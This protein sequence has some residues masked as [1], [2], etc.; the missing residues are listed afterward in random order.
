MNNINTDIIEA[1][2]ACLFEHLDYIDAQRFIAEIKRDSFD[3]TKW[4]RQY[5]DKMEPNEF[6]E[7]AV[8]Y[9]KAHPYDGKGKRL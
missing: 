4:Q 1:G 2:L 6:S 9:A 3:Y 7:Q 8:A 5:F